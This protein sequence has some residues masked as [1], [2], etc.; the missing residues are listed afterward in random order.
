VCAVQ[1]ADQGTVACQA[2]LGKT[3]KRVRCFGA[4][5]TLPSWQRGC[6]CVVI[7]AL[8]ECVQSVLYSCGSS[9]LGLASFEGTSI[10]ATDQSAVTPDGPSWGPLLPCVIQFARLKKIHPMAPSGLH[11]PAVTPVRDL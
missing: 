5:H 8:V 4:A 9:A 10:V 11:L 7:G 2:T 6:C 1:R 3:S